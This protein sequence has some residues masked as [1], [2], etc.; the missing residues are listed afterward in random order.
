MVHHHDDGA[1]Y[2]MTCRWLKKMIATQLN[3]GWGMW[4]GN[5]VIIVKNVIMLSYYV[6][7]M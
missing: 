7:V 3:G 2:M 6:V 4:G 5:N 1:L